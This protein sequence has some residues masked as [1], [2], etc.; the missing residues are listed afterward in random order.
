MSRTDTGGSAFPTLGKDIETEGM[1]TPQHTPG[2]WRWEVNVKHKSV[3]LVGGGPRRQ[4][5]LTIIQPIRW[6]MGSAGLFVRDTAL[7][8]YDLLHKLHERHDWIAPFPGRDHHAHWC[9][10]VVHPDMRLIEAAP[11]L[12]AALEAVR[13]RFFPANQPERDQDML[14]GP[15]N[16]AINQ[17]RGQEGGAA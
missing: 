6:G 9:A 13:D 7:D 5:D 17:A 11:R 16:A 4:F 2:P 8:G 12:L 1:T 14:W 3:Q 10:S 15:V